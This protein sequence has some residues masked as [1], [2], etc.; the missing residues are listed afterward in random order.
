M[1]IQRN[2]LGLKS[3]EAVPSEP[4]QTD[5][6][7]DRKVPISEKE[8][9]RRII[10]IIIFIV[11]WL[12]IFEGVLRKWALPGFQK[13]LFFIR[14]PFVLSI[15]L[16][17][18]KYKMWPKLNP[19]FVTGL[20]LAGVFF[21]L[22]VIQMMTSDVSPIIY[23]YG[24]RNY[25]LYLP[26]AFIIGEQF[27]GKDL[28]RLIK[29]TLIVSIPIAILCYQQFR[30]PPDSSINGTYT[31]GMQAML[32]SRGLVRTSGTFTV[33][34]AQT[35]YIGS[36]I[37]FLLTS[38]LLPKKQRPLH[39]ILLL[40]ASASTLAT[41]AVSGA[42]SVFFIAAIIAFAALVSILIM[43]RFKPRLRTLI[44]LP[45]VLIIGGF[46]YVTFF[47]DAFGAMVQRQIDANRNEGST[48]LRVFGMFY[49][50][51]RA[52][53]MLSLMGCGIGTGTNAAYMTGTT[54]VY[55]AEDEIQ[56]V[57][58]ETGILGVLYMAYRFWFTAWLVLYAV[59]ATARSHNPLPLILI[60]YESITLSIGQMTMQGT[61]N[62]YGWMFAGFCIAAN[63][64]A[65]RR[66]RQLLDKE[67]KKDLWK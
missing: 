67:A 27:R 65:L 44:V 64:L 45:A 10:V 13:I 32:V 57:V 37:A 18:I 63:R 11:Y 22:T 1:A 40:I 33:S 46:C 28:K 14:D 17:A 25:F 34:G 60:G 4:V 59:K 49:S 56:R 3:I 66:R 61:I 43:H 36:L 47:P 30:S 24:W 9:I 19:V 55:L 2:K 29:H 38:W 31:P 41:F 20:V 6:S 51:I 5:S 50:I 16:L 15:Y 35:M 7:P 39:Q 53:S 23:L 54:Q 12:L 62:G 58:L 42:R 52:W 26:F 48:A 21:M 8:K